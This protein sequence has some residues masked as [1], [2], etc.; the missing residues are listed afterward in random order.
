MVFIWHAFSLR[1]V[2][3]RGRLCRG[4]RFEHLNLER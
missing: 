3:P 4:P 2:V 1:F